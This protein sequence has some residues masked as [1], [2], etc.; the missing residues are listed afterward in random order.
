ME[1]LE[2]LFDG[3]ETNEPVEQQE[4]A[5]IEAQPEQAN[6][7]DSAESEPT[8]VEASTS[9]AEE[10]D[11]VAGLQAGITAERQKRHE[12]EERLRQLEAY[13]QGKQSNQQQEKPDFW[14]NPEGALQ[15]YARSIQAQNWQMLSDMSEEMMR[16]L[17]SDYDEVV[18]GKFHE[19]AQ[20]NPALIQQMRQSGNPAKFAYETS[21]NQIRMEQMQDP[22]YEEKLKAKL[23]EE[24]L[25]E[26][27]Q[28]TEQEIQKL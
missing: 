23:K 2:T 12:A 6:T 1:K 4:Q 5:P 26:Q 16:S 9:E 11:P 21:K 18:G 25:A 19:M 22:Q 20:Q 28:A 10:K 14:E 15:N 13:M 17:H 7:D 24:I 3:E 8:D 27:K